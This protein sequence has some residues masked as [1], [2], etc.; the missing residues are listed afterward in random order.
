VEAL[1]EAILAQDAGGTR[2]GVEALDRKLGQLADAVAEQTERFSG[3]QLAPIEKRLDE[4]QAQ[5]E[6]VARR[7]RDSTAQ[8]GPFAKKLEEIADRVSAIGAIGAP[9]P[10]STRLASIEERLT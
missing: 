8:L 7:T 3:T 4:M 9:S 1:G 6:D 2:R 10:L 5:L